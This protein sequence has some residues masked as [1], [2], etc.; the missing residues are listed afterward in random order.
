MASWSSAPRAISETIRDDLIEDALRL[1]FR[2]RLREDAAA[3]V[4]LHGEPNGLKPRGVQ[5]KDQKYLWGSCGRDQVVN[6]NWHLVF[7]P[8]TVLEYAVVHE[9][10]HLRHRNHD[11]DF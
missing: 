11:K 5:V 10:C 6:L 1:W 4:R 9:L 2:R 8:K 3:L 7:A